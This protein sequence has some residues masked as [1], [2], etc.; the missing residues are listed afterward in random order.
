MNISS[1]ISSENSV[2]YVGTVIGVTIGTTYILNIVIFTNLAYVIGEIEK[3][4][5]AA[6]IFISSLLFFS[7]VVLFWELKRELQQFKCIRN[8]FP[9]SIKSY[10]I[11]EEEI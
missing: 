10:R 4:S 5:V 9:E 2:S 8:R 6:I 7:C 3:H 11:K 1:T